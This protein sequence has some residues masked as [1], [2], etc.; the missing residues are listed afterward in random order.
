[1][2]ERIVIEEP[3]VEI[4]HQQGERNDLLK[5]FVKDKNGEITKEITFEVLPHSTHNTMA[6]EDHGE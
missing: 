1:M 4:Y 3:R 2:K 5:L 6:F